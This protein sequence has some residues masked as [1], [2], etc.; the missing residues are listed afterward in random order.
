MAV[1]GSAHAETGGFATGGS[2][3]D[4]GVG[5]A[6]IGER[7]ELSLEKRW[8]AARI[9]AGGSWSPV[10]WATSERRFEPFEF[11]IDCGIVS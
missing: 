6:V 10:W 5:V 4:E 7:P 1:Q 9:G 2:D 8:Q 3:E 11:L